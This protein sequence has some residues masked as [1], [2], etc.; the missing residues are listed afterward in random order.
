M[1]LDAERVG[2]IRL[3]GRPS[4]LRLPLTLRFCQRLPADSDVKN[5]RCLK[6][7]R[8]TKDYVSLAQGN[9]PPRPQLCPLNPGAALRSIIDDPF[10]NRRPSGYEIR[11]KPS[12]SVHDQV[13]DVSPRLGGVEARRT[14]NGSGEQSRETPPMRRGVERLQHPGENTARTEGSSTACYSGPSPSTPQRFVLG[15]ATSFRRS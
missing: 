13:S 1:I 6:T 12:A 9:P 5:D 3:L 15:A 8:Q 2:S 4:T 7:G 10:S 11:V 14:R